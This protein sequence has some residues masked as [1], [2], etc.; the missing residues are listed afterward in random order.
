MMEYPMIGNHVE[1]Y[2]LEE[3]K[4][5]VFNRN[6]GKTYTLGSNES[7]VYLLLNGSNTVD[8]VLQKC[9]FYSSQETEALIKAFSDLGFFDKEKKK[10]NPFKIKLRLFNPNKL[11][12]T[13]SAL[14]RL[15]HYIILFMCPIIF[16]AGIIMNRF[17]IDDAIG[18]YG[19][20]MAGIAEL[21]VSGWTWIVVL[22]LISLALHECAHMITARKYGVNVPEIG[23][24]LYFLVPCAYTNISGIN[25]L[26]NKT[27]RLIVLASGSLV[28]LAVIGICSI[29]MCTT[30]S[31]RLISYA[32]AL[33]LSN[34]GTVFLN[35]M[36][37]LKF[38]GYYALEVILDEPKLREN[39]LSSIV[40]S[41][42]T[43]FAGKKE[44]RAAYRQMLSET[45]NI[46]KYIVYGVYFVFSTGYIPVIML[47]T[48][49]PFFAR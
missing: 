1:V 43:A 49:I 48:V 27:Q 31:K 30:D 9:P 22:S 20:A 5:Q 41:I 35:L 38:D 26:K 16:I 36:V 11:I 10:F 44:E 12:K 33:A 29:T 19:Q 39:A 25:L 14:T 21:G 3:D 40:A 47:N 34:I 13:D 28:N 32:A 46:L 2:P 8:D 37:L 18:F 7:A 4:L 15:F 23:V 42:R 17:F 24:M 45:E 6:T